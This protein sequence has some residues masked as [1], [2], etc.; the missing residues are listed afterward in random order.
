MGGRAF[1]LAVLAQRTGASLRGAGETRIE[2]TATLARAAPGAIAFLSNPR[3]RGDL[4]NC[5]ASA[6]ILAPALADAT[7]LPALLHDNPYACFARVAAL[8]DPTPAPAIGVHPTASVAADAQLGEGVSIG[9]HAVVGP[10]ARIGAGS[11]VHAHATVCH[12]VRIGT[13]AILHPQSVIGSDGFGIAREDGRWIKIPQTGAVVLGDDVE[14]G[15]GTT[16]DRGAL[17]DTVIGDGVK[18]DNQIQVG[19]NVRIGAHSALA[20]CVGI[21]GSAVIGAH[22]EI[23]GGAIILGHLEI[24]DH[25][26]VSAGTMVT[27]SIRVP[28]VYSGAHPFV[29][30]REWLRNGAALR[31]LGAALDRVAALERRIRALEGKA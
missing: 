2:R 30:H 11:V 3:Y 12:G 5:R 25:V 10:G 20:G 14:V 16:I 8:L 17:D 24:C 22:C 1:S 28:G 6:V 23:G 21:A 7:T 26:R 18:F 13:R 9:P 19:H 4:A 15:A 31:Q 29:P 27:K